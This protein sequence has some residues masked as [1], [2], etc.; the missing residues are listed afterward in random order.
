VTVRADKLTLGDLGK[1]LGCPVVEVPV[2][3]RLELDLAQMA[4]KAAGAGFIYV[5]NPNNPTGTLH[6]AKAIEE[7]V[8]AALQR[9]PA[10]T[11]L[12]DE[13]Y[14]EY[15]ER[16]D[17]H[18]AIPIALSNPRVVVSRT[19]SKIYGLAGLRIGYAVA[20]PDVVAQLGKVRGAF[21]VSEL[22]FAAA[23]AS[24]DSEA[25]LR[26]RRTDNEGERERLAAG[27]RT[28]GL[29]PLPAAANF[30][31][32]DVG[33][34]AELAARLEREGVI[35]RPLAGFGAPTC[36]R[37]T[38]GLPDENDAFLAALGRCLQPA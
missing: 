14:H 22:A 23:V 9:E 38:V 19:F 16:E 26:R 34:G 31:C 28:L 20:Q 6:G 36:V 21:D 18:T 30:L 37:V 3:G 1:H 8:T 11:I 24:L 35:V 4:D 13:A 25:E 32:A 27:M 5:C 29:E 17:Y 15:V 2:T 10:V 33:D 12:I 7:F